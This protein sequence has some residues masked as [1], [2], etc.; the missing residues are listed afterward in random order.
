MSGAH[1]K[2]TVGRRSPRRERRPDGLTA[3]TDC[4]DGP[5]DAA[6]GLATGATVSAIRENG[7]DPEETLANN[8]AH[9]APK[10]RGA[11]LVTGTNVNDLRVALAAGGS[12]R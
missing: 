7:M 5:T 11:L 6:S 1:G 12:R 8:D 4:D 3:N 2:V 9:A 10:A